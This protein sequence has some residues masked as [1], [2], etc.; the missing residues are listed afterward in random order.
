MSGSRA[1]CSPTGEDIGVL[2][3]VCMQDLLKVREGQ[4]WWELLV[5][6]SNL[7]T[8]LAS[9]STRLNK[10]S[11]AQGLSL[12]GIAKFSSVNF[13]HVIM[14][15]WKHFTRK[16]RN[17]RTLSQLLPHEVGPVQAIKR[18]LPQGG[19]ESKRRCV[20]GLTAIKD[21]QRAS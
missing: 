12:A 14:D 20:N 17:C 10:I 13:E 8:F 4:P 11:L 5:H 3:K 1:S 19:R 15:S 9:K 16:T 21:H 18:N 7:C 2:V 6:T